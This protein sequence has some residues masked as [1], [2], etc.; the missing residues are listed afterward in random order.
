MAN[1]TYESL[2]AA[3]LIIFECIAGSR[4]YG[5]N[6]ATS[7]TDIRYIYI[8]PQEEINGFGYVQQVSDDTNDVSGWEIQR[9]I[10]LLGVGNPNVLELLSMPED[11][12]LSKDP[13]YDLLLA[14]KVKF[15]TKTLK[16][17]IGGYAKQQIQ[18][19]KGQ[20]KMMN[21]EQDKVERKGPLDFCYVVRNQGGSIPLLDWIAGV[22]EYD[23]EHTDQKI[24]QGQLVVV[25]IPNMRDVYDLYIDHKNEY[26]RGLVGEDGM[27]NDL[28][29]ASIPQGIRPNGTLY[30]N[31]DG[32]SM[33][34]KEYKKYQEWLE[35]RNDA[36]WVDSQKHGQKIDGK[37]M[38]HCKRLLDMSREI[39]S[40][41]GIVVRRPNADELLKIRRGE[42]DLNQLLE[43]ATKEIAIVDELFEACDLPLKVE[44]EV[45]DRLL[46]AM[47]QEF[48]ESQ[49]L[50]RFRRGA[51]NIA[52]LM[53]E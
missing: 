22:N 6:T 12:I 43:W 3:G 37:N 36:R 25:S 45:L 52:M 19:A 11:V 2:K 24:D 7:D 50:A 42:V 15:I 49:A 29:T 38:L 26:S 44:P 5:T 28:R 27:S 41:Q 17:S 13:V 21:W 47:R 18:K 23:L 30:Y 9:F 39:A 4:A 8:L 31:K 14:E 33:H 51:D 1:W 32:Y 34:C 35:K 46:R 53:E 40:G 16:N 10:E 20:D 48:Y